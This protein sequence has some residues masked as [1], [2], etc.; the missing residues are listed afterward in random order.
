MEVLG[1]FRMIGKQVRHHEL[2]NLAQEDG[3]GCGT[4]SW[5]EWSRKETFRSAAETESI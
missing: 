3:G 5:E 2:W 1:I 4:N